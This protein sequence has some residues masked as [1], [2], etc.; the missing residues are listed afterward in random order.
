MERFRF[1]FAAASALALGGVL[2]VGTAQAGVPGGADA[3]RAAAENGAIIEQAQ[4]RWGGYN[5]CWSDDGWRGP[6]WY[7]CG[8]A[9]RPGFGWGGPIGWNNW[10]FGDRDEF[11][12][13]REHEWREHERGEWREHERGEWRE[14]RE[15]RF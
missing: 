4:F 11:R 2:T 7:W 9:Y 3:V 1:I 8:Y 10:R 14:H 15:H 12:E 13:H 6:G 5:Y